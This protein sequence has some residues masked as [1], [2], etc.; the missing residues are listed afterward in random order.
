[1]ALMFEQHGKYAAMNMVV[2]LGFLQNH[3]LVSGDSILNTVIPRTAV[4]PGILISPSHA[5][6][7]Q[8]VKLEIFIGKTFW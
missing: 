4:E 7:K 3:W 6:P 1:M 8:H 5:C 2:L